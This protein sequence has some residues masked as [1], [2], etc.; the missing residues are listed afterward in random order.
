LLKTVRNSESTM[1]DLNS[2]LDAINAGGQNSLGA[3]LRAAAAAAEA[4]HRL[5]DEL[6]AAMRDAGLFRMW[7]PKSLGGLE[8][9]CKTGVRIFEELSRFDA[10]AGWNAHISNVVDIYG[11]W[12]PDSASARVFGGPQHLYSGALNPPFTATPS[13]RGGVAGYLFNGRAPFA[14]NITHADHM[15]ALAL[16]PPASADAPPSVFFAIVPRTDLIVHEGTW[17][18]MGMA[19]TGSFDVEAKDLF[20]PAD[21]LAPLGPRQSTAAAYQTQPLYRL[22]IWPLVS[23]LGAP[24][25]GVARAAIDDFVALATIKVPFYTQ[26]TLRDRDVVQSRLAHAEATLGAARAYFYESIDEAMAA[27][28]EPGTSLSQAAKYKLQLATCQAIERSAEVTRTMFEVAGSSGFRRG[29]DPRSN[30]EL[31][32]EKYLRDATTMTQHAFGSASRYESV[33]QAMLGLDSDW[34]FFAF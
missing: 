24:A 15:L 23:A 7:R 1:S 13:E 26:R 27:V 28:A 31:R 5:S 17:E 8:L 29:P 9:D 33:G 20:V 12:F 2:L 3:R 32:F 6:V 18:T 10:S 25:L 19:A 16:V 22:S 4:N 30:L 11:A 21:Q 14:S 34:P